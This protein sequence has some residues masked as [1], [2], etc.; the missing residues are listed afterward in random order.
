MWE[1]D[2]TKLPFLKG[3]GLWSDC[4]S[5]WPFIKSWR[6]FFHC[7]WLH[8]LPVFYLFSTPLFSFLDPLKFLDILDFKTE[9]SVISQIFFFAA[10]ADSARGLTIYGAQRM[11][12]HPWNTAN[13]WKCCRFEIHL[14]PRWRWHTF[15][16]WRD[17]LWYCF[18]I[19]GFYFFFFFFDPWPS[20]PAF[21]LFTANWDKKLCLPNNQNRRMEQKLYWHCQGWQWN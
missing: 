9:R 3:Y 11:M 8:I 17:N 20:F 12:G 1:Q 14:C 15:N 19:L 18:Y 10:S 7:T 2:K 21:I 4:G 13:R 5:G 6:H 16:H